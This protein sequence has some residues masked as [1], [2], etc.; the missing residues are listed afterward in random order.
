MS[1][2]NNIPKI[3]GDTSKHT[4][5]VSQEKVTNNSPSFEGKQEKCNTN[6]K[7]PQ[8]AEVAGRSLVKGDNL[9]ND[10]KFALA[11]PQAINAANDF[12]EISFGQL[13]KE[14]HPN[15]YEEACAQTDA[16]INECFK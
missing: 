3:S 11:N 9:E 5:K 2:I 6:Q 7:L 12:F 14:G 1:E 8:S 10:I 4:D 16:F 15:A 13:L